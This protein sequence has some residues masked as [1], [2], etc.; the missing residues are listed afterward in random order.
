MGGIGKRKAY[1]ASGKTS[2]DREADQIRRRNAPSNARTARE[3][4]ETTESLAQE[5][6]LVLNSYQRRYQIQP[7]H[8][9]TKKGKYVSEA[10]AIKEGRRSSLSHHD[11]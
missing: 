3:K 2:K 11:Q 10:D 4:D 5:T 9:K 7:C 6:A 8:G 1:Y